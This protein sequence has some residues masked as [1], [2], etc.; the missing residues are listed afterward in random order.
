MNLIDL[1]EI[2]VLPD[3]L[4]RL[5]IRRLLA[6]RLRQEGS[7]DVGEPREFLRE[8]VA[9]LRR[10]L[11]AI[12][13]DSANLQHYEVPTEFFQRVL[14]PQLKYG[15]CYWPRPETTLAE[16]EE[17]MLEL[18]CRR[19]GIED[20]MEILELGCGWGS[21]CLWI[22]QHYPNCRVLAISNSGTQR[23]YILSHGSALALH[24]VEGKRSHC[25]GHNGL[26]C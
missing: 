9:E 13:A 26:R 7:R 8:F 2:G 4:I 23:Q 12:S 10:S 15:S 5:G 11:I 19:A 14:G 16:A 3:W 24:N 17:A 18:F 6:A 22:A 20:G 1:A 21:L 25:P